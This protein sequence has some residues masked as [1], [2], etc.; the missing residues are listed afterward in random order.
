MVKAGGL[1]SRR[2]NNKLV[3]SYPVPESFFV[4]THVCKKF[5]SKWFLG[6]VDQT[7]KDEDNA[8]W[9]VTY[10]DFDSEEVDRQKLSSMLVHGTSTAIGYEGGY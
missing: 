6:V 1:S 2:V 5:G 8:V 9:K 4:G 7:Y 10:S 3:S